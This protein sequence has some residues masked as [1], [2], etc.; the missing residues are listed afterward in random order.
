[1][2]S[3]T[4]LLTRH[5]CL[6]VLDAASTRVQVGLL[7]TRQLA[8]WHSAEVESGTGL[9]I[10]VEDVL[11]KSGLNMAEIGAFIFCEGPGSTLGVR[12]VAM[13]VRSWQTIAARPCPAYRY[14]SLPLLA[15]ELA[16][17]SPTVPCAAVADARRDSWHCV[18]IDPTR[19]VGPLQR[20][21][22][23]ALAT[24]PGEL[25]QPNS[26]RSWANPPRPTLDYPYD[27]SALLAAH[28]DADLFTAT[29]APDAFQ[30]TAPD[31]KKWSAQ[32]HSSPTASSP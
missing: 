9:F 5:G 13:A 16:R 22:S 15:Q 1:M 32:I 20:L 18:Q 6:L 21:A 23:P 4:Q 2:P 30:H 10:G 24:L 14:Q 7:R 28:A 11:K 19:S 17:S 26:F 12:T 27:V 25:W 8:S 29:D 3:L 31:Y